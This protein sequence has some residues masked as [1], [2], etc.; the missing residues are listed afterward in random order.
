MLV[1]I[2]Q[3]DI[4]NTCKHLKSPLSANSDYP[5][6]EFDQETFDFLQLFI[7]LSAFFKGT[8]AYKYTFLE[9]NQTDEVKQKLSS[10]CF[11]LKSNG[12]DPKGI[13]EVH[14][15]GC[16]IC[17]FALPD[18]YRRLIYNIPKHPATT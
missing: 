17:V 1:E 4:L 14:K 11:E 9:D 15:N 16:F 6:H 7:R 13:Y 12:F 5:I 10:L 3:A 2:K 8:P 18:E